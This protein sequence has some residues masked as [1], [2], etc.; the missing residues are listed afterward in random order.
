MGRDVQMSFSAVLMWIAT[1]AG[2]VAEGLGFTAYQ[3]EIVDNGC[4]QMYS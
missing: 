3:Q 1:C 4:S 2:A